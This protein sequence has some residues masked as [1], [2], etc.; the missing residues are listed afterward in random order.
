MAN[1]IKD[2][3]A[4]VNADKVANS[5]WIKELN[6]G[7]NK[8]LALG[9]GGGGNDPDQLK[10]SSGLPIGKVLT[11]KEVCVESVTGSDAKY[12]AVKFNEIANSASL[13]AI[14]ASPSSVEGMTISSSVHCDTTN[15]DLTPTYKECK[16][17]QMG[18][19]DLP[20]NSFVTCVLAIEE[21]KWNL[22][23]KKV[24]YYGK[25]IRSWK[26]R[27]AGSTMFD[28]QRTE[29]YTSVGDNCAVLVPVY[30]MW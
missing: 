15:E 17:G 9:S 20:S 13:R 26:S 7:R 27:K 12:L 14:L 18:V 8:P 24:M 3:I 16:G 29:H 25:A 23:G 1:E 6:K 30:G 10:R 4:S 11:I 2:F 22:V 5:A 21:G 28:A 19:A